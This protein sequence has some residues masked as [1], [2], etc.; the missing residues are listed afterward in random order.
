[1]NPSPLMEGGH[2]MRGRCILQRPSPQ[3]AN[4]VSEND[5][6]ELTLKI[7]AHRAEWH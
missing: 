3:V 5:T 2:N 6:G 1:M 7:N 4:K